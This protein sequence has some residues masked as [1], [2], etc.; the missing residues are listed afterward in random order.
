MNEDFNNLDSGVSLH[1]G[2]PNPAEQ[3]LSL[4]L[5]QLVIKHPSSTYLFKVSGHSWSDQGIYDGDLAVIDRGLNVKPNDLVVAWQDSGF[6]ILK[7][8]HLTD[9]ETAWGVIS[10]VIHQLSDG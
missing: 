9:N 2:F 8:R 10:A 4:D 6:T 5:N 1:R 3:G 7:R